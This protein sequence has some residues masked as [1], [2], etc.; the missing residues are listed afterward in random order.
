MK[1]LDKFLKEQTTVE[2][3]LK[4]EK[5]VGDVSALN[6]LK[7]QSLNGKGLTEAEQTEEMF[8]IVFGK[9][10]STKILKSLEMEAIIMII[11]EISKHF[12]GNEE[13]VKKG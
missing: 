7:L 8:I 13:E 5:I 4:G 9:E 11:S 10:V 6:L 3:E 1:Q 12:G 2:Y